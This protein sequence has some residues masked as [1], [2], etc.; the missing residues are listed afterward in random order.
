LG[1]VIAIFF[2]LGSVFG[3]A[4]DGLLIMHTDGLATRWNVDDYPGL[5]GRHPSLIA[6]VLYR[7]F[8]RNRDDVTVLAFASRSA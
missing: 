2:I 7:D 8:S 3:S 1:V 4:R 6:A 5:V